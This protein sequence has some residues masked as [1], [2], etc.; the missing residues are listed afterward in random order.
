MPLR[1]RNDRKITKSIAVAIRVT[2]AFELF[3][4]APSSGTKHVD[5]ERASNIP[6]Q[7]KPSGSGHCALY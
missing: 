5:F 4:L 3:K 2:I 6:S 1:A 7:L